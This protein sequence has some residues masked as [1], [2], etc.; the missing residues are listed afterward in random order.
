MPKATRTPTPRRRSPAIAA[1]YDF[2]AVLK[3]VSDHPDAKL[4][5]LVAS[6]TNAFKA[7][8]E[9]WSSDKPSARKFTLDQISGRSGS[10]LKSAEAVATVKATTREGALAKLEACLLH[11]GQRD[12]ELMMAS[13][14]RDA[15]AVGI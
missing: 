14:I 5:S 6:Y 8:Q 2:A 15:I 13:A 7:V 9:V 11:L 10:A 3:A 12:V 4:I 1:P